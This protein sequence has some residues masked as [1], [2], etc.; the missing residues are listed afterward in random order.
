ML[1]AQMSCGGPYTT[2]ATTPASR[3]KPYLYVD[4][5]G[6]YQVLRPSCHD[7]LRW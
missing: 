2:L 5:A 4:G 3:E 7:E 6:K 1:P